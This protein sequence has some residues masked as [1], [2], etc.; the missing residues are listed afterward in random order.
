[1]ATI[2]KTIYEFNAFLVDISALNDLALKEID[3]QSI[4]IKQTLSSKSLLNFGIFWNASHEQ[5]LLNLKS[6]HFDNCQTSEV[7]GTLN[8]T[9]QLTHIYYQCPNFKIQISIFASRSEFLWIGRDESTLN[10]RSGSFGDIPRSMNKFKLREIH[11]ANSFKIRVPSDVHSFLFNYNH[12]PFL[13]CNYALAQKNIKTLGANYSQNAK[14][15]TMLLPVMKNISKTLEG[16]R[17]HY[18]LAGGTLLGWYRDCGIIPHTQDVDFAIWAH[19]YE[20]SIK[21][22]FL[23]NK[24]VRVWGTLGLVNDSFEFRMFNDLFTF[25]MFLVY[26]HNQSD[27]WCGYQVNRAKFRRYLP[28]FDKLCSA[29]LLNNRFMVPCDPV[30][31]LNRE[32][33]D[34][35]KWYFPQEKNYT[36]SNVIYDSRWKDHEWPNVIRYYDKAGVLLKNKVLE[37]VNKHLKQNISAIADDT[38]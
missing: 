8:N 12:S 3:R 31:Y 29:E 21:K 25:D 22:A 36:W 4:D 15:N 18:W 24:V 35:K 37:Y 26:K 38:D 16:L 7:K 11:D 6:Q 14:K 9:P 28:N 32:Y 13:E 27:Q 23:G 2:L 19:E 10:Y 30:M 20:T 5:S 1:M 34:E 33:G 17:K